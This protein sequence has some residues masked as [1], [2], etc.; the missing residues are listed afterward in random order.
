MQNLSMI[1]VLLLVVGLG[2]FNAPAVS[3]QT[4][5]GYSSSATCG[6]ALKVTSTDQDNQTREVKNARAVAVRKSNN[7]SIPA[8]LV[9]GRLQ[10]SSLRTADYRLS[11]TKRGFKRTVQ[12]LNFFCPLPNARATADI[13]LEPG[14]IRQSVIA[15][16]Q[17][18]TAMPK[19]VTTVLGSADDSG[20]RPDSSLPLA[21]SASGPRPRAPISGGVLNGKALELVRPVYPPIARAAHASGTVVVQVTIGEDGNI[22]SAHAV[23]GHPLLQAVSVDAARKSKFSPTKLAGQPVKVT[24]VITYNFIAQ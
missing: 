16:S 6:L 15:A 22:V 7:R 24:G 13:R 4:A 10:F 14:S 20:A 8:T 18:V 19:R 17:S 11:I 21:T 2:A 5:A 3:A 12:D 9:S 23:S 1:A